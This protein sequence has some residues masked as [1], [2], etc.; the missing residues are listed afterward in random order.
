MNIRTTLLFLAILALAPLG[1]F[2]GQ[3]DIMVVVNGNTEVNR[4]AFNFIRKVFR[5]ENVNYNVGA[6]LDPSSVKPG[7]YKAVVV[8]NT[9]I[10]TGTDPVL[11]KFIQG[12]TDKK[13]L[14]LV[15]L[16]KGSNDLKVTTFTAAQSDLGVDGIS[17]ASAW[18]RGFGGADPEQMH[19]QWVEQLIRFL[20]SH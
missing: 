11:Q 7:Q 6:T 16:W 4:E 8:L 1:A 5:Y 19:V 14:F 18:G 3:N 17:A 9:S 13:S 2:A 12:Y 20:Q 10:R 15:N